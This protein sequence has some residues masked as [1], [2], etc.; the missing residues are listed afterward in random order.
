[1]AVKARILPFLEGILK[2]FSLAYEHGAELANSGAPDD[3]DYLEQLKEKLVEAMTCIVHAVNEFPDSLQILSPHLGML[4]QFIKITCADNLNPTVEY[5]RN[6]V[7][8]EVDIIEF[9]P[10]EA[11][12]LLDFPFLEH[13]L[14]HL[15]KYEKD[16]PQNK[17]MIEY[18]TEVKFSLHLLT[19]Y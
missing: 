3:M 6:C 7:G 17:N 12:N 18:A 2:Y 13:V 10:S 5:L 14:T 11:R 1:M 15:K 9:Y 4:F 8:L 16:I 19:P